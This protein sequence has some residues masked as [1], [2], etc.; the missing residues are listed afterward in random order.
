MHRGGRLRA[1]A[2]HPEV[3][4]EGERGAGRLWLK[5]KASPSRLWWSCCGQH[6]PSAARLFPQAASFGKCF[7]DK[8]PPESFVRMCQDLRVL[9][10]IRDYQIGIPLTYTQ[11]PPRAGARVM[12]LGRVWDL[13]QAGLVPPGAPGPAGA[14]TSSVEQD[15]E[16]IAAELLSC[17]PRRVRAPAVPWAPWQGS[18]AETSTLITPAELRC[19]QSRASPTAGSGVLPGGG[20]AQHMLPML[21]GVP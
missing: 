15:R 10:A 6:S 3:S 11:Y 1:R 7:I 12:A 13:A 19:L 16:G 18:V 20:A 2:G 21:P 4:A 9:N 14:A 17:W 5:P 8:F